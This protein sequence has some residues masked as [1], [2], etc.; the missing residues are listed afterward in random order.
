MNDLGEILATVVTMDLFESH[1]PLV[2][3]ELSID[4]M[5]CDSYKRAVSKRMDVSQ[6]DR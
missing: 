3:N 5:P 4:I 6:E 2:K 1:K